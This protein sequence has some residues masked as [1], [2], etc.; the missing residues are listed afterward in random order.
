MQ[1]RWWD[2]LPFFS[3]L[4]EERWRDTAGGSHVHIARGRLWKACREIV[5]G[6]CLWR[7]GRMGICLSLLGPRSHW[8][9]S[10]PALG[11]CYQ[12]PRGYWWCQ[13]PP[14]SPHY[15][16]SSSLVTEWHLVCCGVLAKREKELEE[17]SPSLRSQTL[18]MS[19][20]LCGKDLWRAFHGPTAVVKMSLPGKRQGGQ[21]VNHTK[22]A[23]D[24]I[25][26]LLAGRS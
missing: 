15:G 3:L 19:S 26:R 24:R 16:I 6:Y 13:T 8:K 12:P 1:A 5:P 23:Q 9:A 2:P 7:G 4:C 22:T 18:H 20:L 10:F 21:G 14:F 17:V 11:L 25:W